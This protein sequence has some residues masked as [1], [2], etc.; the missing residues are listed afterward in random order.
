MQIAAPIVRVLALC[1]LFASAALPARAQVAVQEVVSPG[2]IR[3]WLAEEHS[4]PF[5]AL[6]IRF[7]GGA[8]LDAPERRGAI[9]L[10][11]ALL[12]EGAGPLDARAFAEAREELAASFA[13]EAS[14]D[15]A[16][17]SARFLSENR[18]ESVA[19]LKLA[20]MEPRF[21][22]DALE[23]VRAQVL[24]VIRSE[25]T[26]PGAIAGRVF[27]RL[28]WG[29]HPYGSSRNG[30]VESVSA[31]G[32][33]DMRDAW[34]RV[35]G[36][37]RLYVAAAGDITAEEL[38]LLLDE[39]LLDLPESA[40]VPPAPEAGYRLEPGVTVVGF[41]TPQAVALFGHE[42]IARDDPDYIP[43]YIL[44]EVFGGRGL[45]SR[46]TREL[47]ER[48]GLT[49]GVSTF[50]LPMEYGRLVMGQVRSDNSRMAESVALIRR[51]WARIAGEGLTGAE[52][53]EAKT[54]L[55][56]AYPLRFDG[57]AP[58]ARILVGMQMIGLPRD[59]IRNRNDMV[60]AVTLEDVNRVAR[61]LYQ[62]DKLHFVVVG[63]PDG[64]PQPEQKP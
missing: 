57:N 9:N 32:Q 27:D 41:D 24:A 31:L 5:T 35:F 39:L 37:D 21:D 13:F 44:N 60:R 25:E 47:R 53:E 20:M 46:L 30:T 63:R 17:I 26:D 4:I 61:R 55:T 16:R 2:G 59:Y 6:E 33:A 40:S 64:L 23:R 19:L 3:A 12:E 38:G 56:G 58:I 10:M 28:A 49:Y 1:A 11:M 42:G 62:P 15:V 48:R 36:R 45:Q 50:L 7:R 29:E 54:Y 43:A 52:L 14:D 51:E 18:D 34:A 8:A 22:R